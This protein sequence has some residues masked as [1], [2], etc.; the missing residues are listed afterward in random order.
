MFIRCEHMVNHHLLTQLSDPCATDFPGLLYMIH[1]YLARRIVLEDISVPV[2]SDSV[3]GAIAFL[4]PFVYNRGGL[5][6][7]CI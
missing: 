1:V 6:G 7:A 5:R 4:S 3:R 2:L